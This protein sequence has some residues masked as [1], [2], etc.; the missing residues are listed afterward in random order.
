MNYKIEHLPDKNM[1]SAL[2]FHVSARTSIL[3]CAQTT[4]FPSQ[5][6]LSLSGYLLCLGDVI[7]VAGE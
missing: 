2:K 4:A 6:I 3:Y 7:L 5:L 1:Y